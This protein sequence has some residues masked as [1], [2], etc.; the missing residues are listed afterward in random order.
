MVSS[1]TRIGRESDHW[2]SNYG[3]R[4]KQGKVCKI[5]A[6]RMGGKESLASRNN[7]VEKVVLQTDCRGSGWK[8]Q[9][10]TLKLKALGD[11]HLCRMTVAGAIC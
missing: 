5:L 6:Y 11:C 10:R 4:D 3:S 8:Y 2:D 9:C 7:Y 1:A